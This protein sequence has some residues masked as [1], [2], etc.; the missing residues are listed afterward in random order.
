MATLRDCA[1]R[2]KLLVFRP[3]LVPASHASMRI[4]RLRQHFRDVG[5]KP[6]P[7]YPAARPRGQKLCSLI[8]MARGMRQ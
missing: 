1:A 5:A 2:L 7:L 8:V 6:S 4:A 3:T